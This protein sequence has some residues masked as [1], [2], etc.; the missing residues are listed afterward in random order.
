VRQEHVS[1]AQRLA[2][3]SCAAWKEQTM[4]RLQQA[5]VW[6]AI[7]EGDV[8]GHQPGRGRV[9]SPEELDAIADFGW[10]WPDLGRLLRAF[11]NAAR[12]TWRSGA[13]ARTD[14]APAASV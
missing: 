7:L 12:S 13:T 1:A 2:D 11:V 6:R 4:D 10:P 14:D 3:R 9:M 8:L 5:L